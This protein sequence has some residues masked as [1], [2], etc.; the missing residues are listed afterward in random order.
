ME[1]EHS[2]CWQKP[3]IFASARLAGNPGWGRLIFSAI[4]D[5]A[6]FA[7]GEKLEN[8]LFAAV[9]ASP[10]VILG[11]G[12]DQPVSFQNFVRAVL[13]KDLITPVRIHF[14]GRGRAMVRLSSNFDASA[15]ISSR[16]GFLRPR[17]R[18]AEEQTYGEHNE[19]SS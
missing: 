18:A 16:K 5:L 1:L 11:G 19:Y 13:G 17:R 14:D 8:N 15:F 6:F 3:R 7:A 12:K 9:E 4:G 10:S 2:L